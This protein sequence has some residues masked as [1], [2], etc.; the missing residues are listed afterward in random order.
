MRISILVL[1]AITSSACSKTGEWEPVVFGGGLPFIEA[2][3]DDQPTLCLVDTGAAM[4]VY[5]DPSLGFERAPTVNYADRRTSFGVVPAPD[6]AIFTTL[7]EYAGEDV[8]CL[9]GMLAMQ[10]YAVTLDPFGERIRFSKPGPRATRV[11]DLPLGEPIEIPLEPGLMPRTPTSFDGVD[12]IALVDTG[13]G[14]LHVEPWVLD[15]LEPRPDTEPMDIQTP[16]GAFAGDVGSMPTTSLSGVDVSDLPFASYESE[17]L[18]VL[19]DSGLET[20]GIVGMPYLENFV[21]T[22]DSEGQ[23]LTLQ[24]Y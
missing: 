23:T 21:V 19:R 7:S 1:L 5:I 4:G 13:A 2:T 18:A 15:G 12:V 11:D 6:G 20:D 3:L 17:A 10:P 22:F 24:P 16:Y 9:L 8:G 14:T